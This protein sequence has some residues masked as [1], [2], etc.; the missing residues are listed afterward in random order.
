MND[1]PVD[2][3]EMIE[4]VFGQQRITKEEIQ[5]VLETQGG[6]IAMAIRFIE[7]NY[8]LRGERSVEVMGTGALA[9]GPGPGSGDVMDSPRAHNLEPSGATRRGSFAS[10]FPH[11][12]HIQEPSVRRISDDDDDG[13]ATS[14]Y[15]ILEELLGLFQGVVNYCREEVEAR[16]IG[17]DRES[18]ERIATALMSD[19]APE[20]E[21]MFAQF[22]KKTADQREELY[23]AFRLYMLVQGF[24]CICH[25]RLARDV[26]D[27]LIGILSDY[28][29]TVDGQANHNLTSLYERLSRQFTESF[30]KGSGATVSQPTCRVAGEHMIRIF[31]EWLRDN[32]NIVLDDSV[33]IHMKTRIATKKIIA[34]ISSEDSVEE[35]DKPLQEFVLSL[36]AAMFDAMNNV[37]PDKSVGDIGTTSMDAAAVSKD[38]PLLTFQSCSFNPPQHKKPQKTS[39]PASVPA[40]V[41]RACLWDSR[42]DTMYPDTEKM[43]APLSMGPV[44]VVSLLAFDPDIVDRAFMEIVKKNTKSQL[45]TPVV[46]MFGLA[47]HF[48]TDRDT[49]QEADDFY[50]NKF[51]DFLIRVRDLAKKEAD[52]LKLSEV[53]SGLTTDVPQYVMINGQKC[54]LLSASFGPMSV[55]MTT[56]IIKAV[57]PKVELGVRGGG[58]CSKQKISG[59]VYMGMGQGARSEKLSNRNGLTPLGKIV[60]TIGLMLKQFGDESKLYSLLLIRIL[61]GWPLGMF[62]TVDTM[63]ATQYALF[64]STM[65]VAGETIT[66]R[67]PASSLETPRALREEIAEL[68]ARFQI[69]TSKLAD[70]DLYN[71]LKHKFDT[72]CKLAVAD[73]MLPAIEKLTQKGIN[74]SRLP[75]L[76]SA[77]V[78][79][80]VLSCRD[81]LVS[82]KRVVAITTRPFDRAIHGATASKEEFPSLFL[83]PNTSKC[84]T[85]C[86]GTLGS[87]LDTHRKQWVYVGADGSPVPECD[88]SQYVERTIRAELEGHCTES[89]EKSILARYKELIELEG[90]V[91]TLLKQKDNFETKEKAQAA[92]TLG[93]RRTLRSDTLSFDYATIIS[94]SLDPWILTVLEKYIIENTTGEMGVNQSVSWRDMCLTIVRNHFKRVQKLVIPQD[95]ISLSQEARERD[96]IDGHIIADDDG[97]GLSVSVPC[98]QQ[99]EYGDITPKKPKV[100]ITPV[101]PAF[102]VPAAAALP[103]AVRSS[104][105]SLVNPNPNA[106]LLGLRRAQAQQQRNRQ[107]KGQGKGQGQGPGK[108][109]GGGTRKK[110]KI[111]KRK[112][113]RK[114]KGKTS[115]HNHTIK[116]RHI[117]NYSLRNKQ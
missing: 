19:E 9:G 77:L 27:F 68:Q 83:Q 79:C 59:V 88:F 108:G 57:I 60:A 106:A 87:S 72:F 109:R 73:T 40:L 61:T 90:G 10:L 18:I 103:V 28:R 23:F 53:C 112:I 32:Y 81:P 69:Y 67:R 110:S 114:Y 80:D 15:N 113:T 76:I 97:R 101:S 74:N 35:E 116:N 105:Q 12:D 70:K 33:I 50:S 42:D 91:F 39:V 94:E 26:K 64:G 98:S 41:P 13:V 85:E 16:T 45:W 46:L 56:N 102:R 66:V 49:M 1:Q 65:L 17:V 63:A 36:S 84:L 25:D 47:D 22:D 86:V 95:S 96:F 104:I 20:I 4:S 30:S 117:R 11:V 55:N 82:K 21:G 48:I 6:D 2:P 7:D 8:P 34:D 92:L 3:V 44:T 58:G 107:G 51:K 71:D 75:S 37:F 38:A 100:Q 14:M 31:R 78:F 29:V 43:I 93:S 5:K 111:Q 52:R 115:R 24:C 89:D 99:T 54:V 62:G